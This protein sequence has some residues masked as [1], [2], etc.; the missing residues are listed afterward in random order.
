[1]LILESEIAL[2]GDRNNATPDDFLVRPHG[3]EQN[4][5]LHDSATLFHE[6]P[7]G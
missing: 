4:E 5:A 3:V 1:M 6:R 7:W 2:V